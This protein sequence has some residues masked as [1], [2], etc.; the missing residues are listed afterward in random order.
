MSWVWWWTRLIP[1]LRRQRRLLS[2]CQASQGYIVSLCLKNTIGNQ[3]SSRG[4]AGLKASECDSKAGPQGGLLRTHSNTLEARNAPR[5]PRLPGDHLSQC[6]Y[7]LVG[8][9]M[10]LN[11]WGL[12]CFVLRNKLGTYFYFICI[13]KHRAL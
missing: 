9:E 11:S 4:H 3:K 8:Q 7:C 5:R 1:A 2:E 6:S 12:F 10:L 13:Y